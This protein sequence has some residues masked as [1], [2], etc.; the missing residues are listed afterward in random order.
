MKKF[1]SIIPAALI[2]LSFE[3]LI[4]STAENSFDFT[5]GF[6][7]SPLLRQFLDANYPDGKIPFAL[8]NELIKYLDEKAVTEYEGGYDKTDF[9]IQAVIGGEDY[10]YDGRFD[11][12]GGSVSRDGDTITEHIRKNAEYITKSDL[13]FYNDES[14]A[15]ARNTLDVLV[16]FLG[17][18]S[19]LSAE[20]KNILDEF[21]KQNPIKGKVKAMSELS[22]GDVIRLPSSTMLDRN[23]KPVTVSESYA[24]VKS[25]NEKEINLDTYSDKELT[26]K[27]GVAGY[28]VNWAEQL[29]KTGAEYI[30]RY[31]DI[32]ATRDDTPLVN[33]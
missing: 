25:A 6:T 28:L 13:W 9:E 22:E 11:I 21:K 17:K 2:A 15:A 23:L 18:Y 3:T 10:G 1:Y 5:I 12:G 16:P 7:E 30:G 20:E 24:V 33:P 14:K 8:A 4:D 26:H 31:E 29:E 19:E 27:T 32:T